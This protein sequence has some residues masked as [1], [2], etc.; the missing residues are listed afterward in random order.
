MDTCRQSMDIATAT[1]NSLVED[2]ETL[3]EAMRSS[4]ESMKQGYAYLLCS[5]RMDDSVELLFPYHS[6]VLSLQHLTQTL[7]CKI[8]LAMLE[9]PPVNLAIVLPSMDSTCRLLFS[10]LCDLYTSLSPVAQQTELEMYMALI[11]GPNMTSSMEMEAYSLMFAPLLTQIA[12]ITEILR[13]LKKEGAKGMSRSVSQQSS[14]IVRR[15]QSFLIMELVRPGTS[16]APKEVPDYNQEFT[17]SWNFV[18]VHP[19]ERQLARGIKSADVPT[20][21][22]AMV[23]S[24]VTESIRIDEGCLKYLLKNDVLSTLVRLSETDRPFGIQAEVL[25]VVQNM[26]ILL[27][28][29]FLIHSAI[30]KAVFRLLRNCVGD[31]LHEQLDGRHKKVMGAAGNAIQTQPSELEEDRTLWL[32]FCAFCAAAYA[33]FVDFS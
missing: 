5:G 9:K 3:Q 31:D 28:E 19:D 11:H 20:H 26:D 21:L 33:H 24:L 23:N 32:I 13:K 1:L 27:D 2:F 12:K 15:T 25:R 6:K 17:K 18:K 16:P 30:H 14:S 8:F 22:Q 10:A 29:Q 7:K 4:I